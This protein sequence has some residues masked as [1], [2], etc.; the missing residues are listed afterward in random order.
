MSY[1]SSYSH[2]DVNNIELLDA[3]IA[4]WFHELLTDGLLNNTMV[5]VMSDHGNRMHDIRTTPAGTIEDRMPMLFLHLPIDYRHRH[6]SVVRALDENVW[7]LT[8]HYD[9]Y[10]TMWS[11]AN[12]GYDNNRTKP[13]RGDSL[14]V[15]G[16]SNNYSTYCSLHK[17]SQSR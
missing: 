9:V 6:P 11:I 17:C 1:I 4:R 2:D 14:Y 5:I 16:N 12:G 3:H 10:A 15:S 13:E 8:T 7:R